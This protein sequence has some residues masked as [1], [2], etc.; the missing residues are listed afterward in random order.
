MLD[1]VGV[2]LVLM[3][4]A[5]LSSLLLCSL[6]LVSS[7]YFIVS[8]LWALAAVKWACLHVFT[9]F[10]SDGKPPAALHGLTALLCLLLPVCESG[11]VLTG[12]S[13]QTY[14]GPSLDLGELLLVRPAC[15]AL[16]WVLWEGLAGW[17]EPTIGEQD[18]T[19]LLTRV[20]KYFK[21]DAVY[22]MAAFTFLILGVV[23]D[24]YV[25]WYQGK[26]V[27][28]LSSRQLTA[29]F[30]VCIRELVLVSLGSALFSAGRGGL[31]KC[32]LARL[33]YRLKLLLFHRLLQQELH[34][35]HLN[36]PGQLSARL[37][38][39][40]DKMG[41]TV[42]LNANA[43]VRSV[44]KTLLMLH[45]MFS[46]SSELTVI[47]C[48]AM[49]LLGALQ[50]TYIPLHK[51]LKKQT[52]DCL[53]HNKQLVAE[54]VGAIRTVRSLGAEPEELRHYDKALQ[55]T[56]SVRRRAGIY[57][58]LYRLLHQLIFTGMKIVMMMKAR[59]LLSTNQLSIGNL[60]TFL[61]YLKPLQRSITEILQSFGNT[62]ATV[63][64][65]SKVFSYLDRTPKRTKDG[66]L[67][68]EELHG[69]VVLR[70]VTF[71]YPSAPDRPAVKGV[72]MRLRPGRL[73]ALVGPSGSGKSSMT[74]LLKRLY[75]PEEGEVLLDGEPLH[76]Y[77]HTFLQEKVALVSQNPVLFSG[78]LR[79]NV[80]YGLKDVPF[81]K[82]R[83][84]AEKVNAHRLISAMESGDNTDI[85]ERGEKLSEGE[86]QLVAVLRVLLR[87]PKV[88]ILDEATSH[89]DLNSQRD[90]LREVLSGGR[91]V[92]VVTHQLHTVETADHIVFMEGG[93]V[94]EEG[95]HAQLME[96]R[97]RY[98][99]LKEEQF[100]EP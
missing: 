2:L 75:E 35:F 90:V 13:F 82:V 37:H 86:K 21:A 4:D 49:A 23:C 31:F 100:T 53:A 5:A 27:D 73:T 28:F 88:L 42:A 48:S 55:R 80:E 61:L 24:T 17:A 57:S 60:L 8:A 32:S 71:S 89:L 30:G 15:A 7:P 16:A 43:M 67:S 87:D 29:D 97:G 10:V 1:A 81:Q 12:T 20:L 99:R 69:D 46:L 25:P 92:L 63:G 6:L 72:S 41:C 59:T 74:L 78:S 11:R 68:P 94:V 33:N 79:Y 93:A 98:R 84:A 83:E 52:Q 95:T 19:R 76:C 22:L 14:S 62:V 45:V 65:I 51:E 34:F 77:T 3:L 39:D 50:K 96:R 40:V 85:G 91:T 38:E 66:L 56:S 47:S 54:T 58:T 36:K 18:T 44:V 70:D 9:S 26:V 64:V